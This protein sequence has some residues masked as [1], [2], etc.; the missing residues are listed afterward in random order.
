M[1]VDCHWFSGSLVFWSTAFLP[2]DLWNSSGL[3]ESGF[4]L[5]RYLAP[6]HL[7]CI[8][9]SALSRSVDTHNEISFSIGLISNVI[10][11]VVWETD[12]LLTKFLATTQLKKSD[13]TLVPFWFK[14]KLPQNTQSISIVTAHTACF[15]RHPNYC[16]DTSKNSM[17]FSVNSAH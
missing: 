16:S 5:S 3:L 15:L 10:L 13:C 1:V 12:G 2:L 14:N 6:I 17:H 7:F 4:W 8:P 11:G 9:R